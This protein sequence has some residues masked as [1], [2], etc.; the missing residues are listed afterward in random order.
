M[1]SARAAALE[2]GDG[3]YNVRGYLTGGLS[4][5]I[6]ADIAGIYRKTDSFVD[7]L[8]RGGKAG[9]YQVVD[10]RSKLMYRGENGNKIILTGDNFDRTGSQNVT[11]H[12]QKKT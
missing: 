4:D 7:D 5:T 2:T 3:D 9:G 8:V 10:V 11:K 6:A 1:V 12:Y